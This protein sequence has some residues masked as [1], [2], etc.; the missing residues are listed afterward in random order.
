MSTVLG[1]IETALQ[2]K[3][4]L[5]REVAE[6][7]AELERAKLAISGAHQIEPRRRDFSR[8]I[9][10][11]GSLPNEIYAALETK[12][13]QTVGDL[14]TAVRR[15]PGAIQPWLRDMVNSKR[16]H[17]VRLAGATGR[18]AIYAR[19]REALDGFVNDNTPAPAPADDEL[20][21]ANGATSAGTT[22]QDSTT[23]AVGGLQ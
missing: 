20:G 11:D 23:P 12:E 18:T 2:R 17:R 10:R 7:D 15:T 13:P 21:Q 19:T 14:A 9:R 5:L 4:D 6:I 22:D 1:A 3:S 8:D 16:L